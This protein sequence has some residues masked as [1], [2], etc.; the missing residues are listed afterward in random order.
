[1]DSRSLLQSRPSNVGTQD[2]MRSVET[3]VT[4]PRALLALQRQQ[5]ALRDELAAVL[6]LEAWLLDNDRLEDWLLLLAEDLRYV[7]PVRRKIENDMMSVHSI[8]SEPSMSSI[9]NDDRMQLT[10]R[11][12]RLRTGFSHFDKPRAAARRLVSNVLLLGW[13]EHLAEATITSNFMLFRTRDQDEEMLFV[14]QRADIWQRQDNG[15]WLLRRRL[16]RL[17]HYQMPPV[18]TFF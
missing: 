6:T 12:K 13:D 8:D 9:F 18:T 1:M 17:E 5:S 15:D 4:D 2:I 7:A 3:T 16:V 14:G 11:I 10:L